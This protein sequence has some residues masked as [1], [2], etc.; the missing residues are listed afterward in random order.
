[1][2]LRLRR[3]HCGRVHSLGRSLAR[4]RRAEENLGHLHQLHDR[5]WQVELGDL[6]HHALD[7][8]GHPLVS[9]PVRRDA[10]FQVVPPPYLI[11]LWTL[12]ELRLNLFWVDTP[13]CATSEV[14]DI[15]RMEFEVFQS[16][17]WVCFYLASV[18]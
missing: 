8:H 6:G 5:L 3:E 4:L 14:R 9:V 17:G 15:Y 2:G 7:L 1:M 13:G 11:N 10:V 16:L 12:L 18:V